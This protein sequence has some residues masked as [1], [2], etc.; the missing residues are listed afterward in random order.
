MQPLQPD[1][2]IK[3]VQTNQVT[4]ATYLGN[5]GGFT[6]CALHHTQYVLGVVSTSHALYFFVLQSNKRK[7]CTD[8]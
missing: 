8:S 5:L 7:N 2:L 1:L 4:S 6:S 3:T